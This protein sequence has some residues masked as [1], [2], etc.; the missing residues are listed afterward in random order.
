MRVKCFVWLKL[1]TR[2]FCPLTRGK[3]ERKKNTPSAQNSY[4]ETFSGSVIKIRFHM[5]S[6]QIFHML[7]KCQVLTSCYHHMYDIYMMILYFWPVLGS[8]LCSF[9]PQRCS[10]RDVTR[11]I[12]DQCCSLPEGDF[13]TWLSVIL[14]N[15]SSLEAKFSLEGAVRVMGQE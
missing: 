5:Q 9:T 4:S 2:N 1:I 12:W 11:L 13:F 10:Q 14:S 15:R 3:E 8:A 6:L 7:F